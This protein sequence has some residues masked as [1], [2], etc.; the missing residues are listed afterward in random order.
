MFITLKIKILSN[1]LY[2]VVHNPREKDIVMDYCERIRDL[3]EDSGLTQTAI[4]KLL[5][6]GQRTYADYEYG[7]TRIPVDRLIQLAKYYDVSMDYICGVSSVRG[8]FPK[9]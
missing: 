9:E 2:S 6:V 5:K 3:R 7:V 1:L 4:G 8:S